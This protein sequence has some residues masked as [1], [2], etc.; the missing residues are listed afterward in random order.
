MTANTH[1]I[2]ALRQALQQKNREIAF[3]DDQLRILSLSL[4]HQVAAR[5]K[6]LIQSRD[7]ALAAAQAKSEFL[8]NMSHEIRTP[9][10]GVLGMLKLLANTQ[11]TPEQKKF[12]VIGR[13][14][15]ELLLSIINDI[16]DFSKISA[17]KMELSSIA[18]QPRALLQETLEAM[19][20]LAQDKKIKLKH[21]CDE[22]MPENLF[23]DPLRITQIISNL[24]SNAVKFT[25]KGSVSVSLHQQENTYLI[26][27][28]DTGIGMNE[29][30]LTRIFNAFDQGDNSITRAYG[31]TG[32]GLTII[33]RLIDMMQGSIH[34]ESTP[35]KG[36]IFTVTLPINIANPED[37]PTE[38]E[39]NHV[40]IQFSGQ[41]ILLV[42]DNHTNQILANYLLSALNLEIGIANNGAE[43]VAAVQQQNYA[44]VLMDL[45]MP[46]MDGLEATRRI[47][48]LGA[49]YTTLP[50]IAMTA[51]VSQQDQ[52]QCSA[53]GMNAHIAKPIDADVL[54]KTL[55]D[56]ITPNI[57]DVATLN[58]LNTTT[59]SNIPAQIEGIDLHSALQRV[60]GNWPFLQKLFCHFLQDQQDIILRI[61]Q[62]LDEHQINTVTITLHTLKGSAANIGATALAAI[63]SKMEQVAKMQQ[64]DLLQP[65]LP[66]LAAEWQRVASAISALDTADTPINTQPVTPLSELDLQNML[67]S[68]SSALDCDL[69]SAEILLNRLMTFSLTDQQ[70]QLIHSIQQAFNN[71]D[72]ESTKKLL[73][74]Y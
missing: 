46:V 7:Q 9:I 71:F 24:V 27:V 45:Q 57:T 66:S 60:R 73:T 36:S 34:V 72:I 63:A 38:Q 2:E 50:I 8:A 25:D 67:Q 32:L 58:S 56:W 10:N 6:A 64:F 48:Q 13:R 74:H 14:S 22:N 17:G 12:V 35:G 16:L 51:N 15:G 28:Q 33:G 68:F 40:D 47:R 11:L 70:S 1:N 4:E 44:A 49:Q 19:D 30:Q 21:S 43:A 5:T 53:A 23:G 52:A 61:Q 26:R 39:N 55:A 37:L 54:A 65:L 18:F 3:K 41:R 42:E 62:Q 20:F 69:A 31:G 59:L 29:V